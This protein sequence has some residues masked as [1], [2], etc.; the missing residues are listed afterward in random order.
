M[1]KTYLYCKNCEKLTE[2]GSYCEYCRKELG[3]N[4]KSKLDII[5]DKSNSHWSHALGKVVRNNSEERREAK[6][7]GL[8]EVGK[9]KPHK[10]IKP[11]RKEYTW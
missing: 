2:L 5:I 3:N 10:Y 4:I 11:N 8:V 1:K 7:R 9:E 6:A